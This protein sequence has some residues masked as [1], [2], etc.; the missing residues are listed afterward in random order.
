MAAI[1]RIL[2]PRAISP[3]SAKIRHW[4]IRTEV[5][6]MKAAQGPNSAANRTPPMIWPDEPVPGMEKLIIWAANMNA[7]KTPIM[8]TRSSRRIVE[9]LREATTTRAAAMTPAVMAT[10]GETKASATCIVLRLGPRYVAVRRS[11]RG[12]FAIL[13]SCYMEWF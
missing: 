3:P 10:G 9:T 6:V 2:Q 1:L 11:T 4:M 5:R 8:G 13:T 7:P 12:V